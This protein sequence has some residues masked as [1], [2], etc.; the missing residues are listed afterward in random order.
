MKEFN[1]K[2]DIV[3][4][5]N[6]FIIL[7]NSIFIPVDLEVTGLLNKIDS[8]CEYCDINYKCMTYKSNLCYSLT[9]TSLKR[10][11]TLC[12]IELNNLVFKYGYTMSLFI[13]RLLIRKI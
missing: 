7:D 13:S 4:V 2:G 8:I 9:S 1:W 3:I 5:C 11:V 6:N 10:D 12:G